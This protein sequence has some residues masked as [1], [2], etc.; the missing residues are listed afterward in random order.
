MGW[1]D[2]QIREREKNDDEMFSQ[3]VAG[4]ADAVSGLKTSL[5]FQS[6]SRKTQS[7]VDELLAYYH[8]KSREVPEE[9]K[10]FEQRLEYQLRPH[11]MMH[12]SVTLEKGW[13]RNATGAMLGVRKED[14]TVAALIPDSVSGYR[15]YDSKSGKRVRVTPATE[16]LFEKDAIVVYPSFPL[17]SMKLSELYSYITR[18]FSASDTLLVSSFALIAALLGLLTPQLTNMIVGSVAESGSTA[19]LLSVTVFM[20]CVTVSGRFVSSAQEIVAKKIGAKIKLGMESTVMMR[21]LSLPPAFFRDYGSGELAGMVQLTDTLGEMLVS[22]LF[23]SGL[24]AVC[25]LVYIPQIFIYAPALM[26]PAFSVILIITIFSV[27]SAFVQTRIKKKQ[28][29]YELKESGVSYALISGIQKIKIAGAEKRAFMRWSKQYSKRAAVEYRP[30]FVV[31]YNTAITTGILLVGSV[32][33]YRLAL[34]SGI[35]VA[36]YY[37]FNS[38]YG[39]LTGAFTVLAENMLKAADIRS[40]LDLLSP[41]LDAAPEVSDGQQTV[42]RLSGGVELNNVSFQY[43]SDMPRVLDNLSLKIKSGEYVAVVGSTGCGKSTLMRIM[44]GMEKPQKGAVYYDGK[45]LSSIDPK[46]LRGKI[47]VVMQNGKLFQGDIYSNIAISAPT[48]TLDDAWKAAELA[49]I[50][51]DIRRMPMGMNTMIS[52]GQGGISGGQ[53]QR[54]MIARAIAAKPKILMFDEATSALDNL[55]QKNISDALDSLKC[56]R[57]VIAHRLSTIRH[58][59]RILYLENGKIIEEGNYEQ[60]IAKNGKFASLVERQQIG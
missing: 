37:A 29:E 59:D 49:G 4:I 57:I 12:R 36:Q 6:D 23:T 38:A 25:S 31:R 28:L 20:I 14:K 18:L 11:G 22:V 41:I 39:M 50:A 44:L 13:S 32:V 58:C 15:Y 53:K 27:I 46:T 33:M 47:G 17:K 40:A 24:S 26:L 51:D 54:L 9:I 21:I 34:T 5:F 8:L 2:E 19:L 30:P 7:A 48:L 55:T 60:L 45:D 52:E 56:T 42:T 10:G 16:E 3:A 35:S 1:F 43:G